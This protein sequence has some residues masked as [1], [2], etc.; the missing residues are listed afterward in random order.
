[1]TIIDALKM[2]LAHADELLPVVRDLVA[3]LSGIQGL[4]MDVVGPPK[5][6]LERLTAMRAVDKIS[7]GDARQF[8]LELDS[9]FAAFHKAVKSL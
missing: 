4:P 5:K 3:S 7:D 9:S 1:V 6:W 2:G 8:A